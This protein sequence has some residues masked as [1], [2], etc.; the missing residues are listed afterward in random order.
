MGKS[1]REKRSRG[2]TLRKE[3]DPSVQ[4]DSKFSFKKFYLPVVV[5][6]S[7][8][9]FSLHLYGADYSRRA[10]ALTF[11]E[12]LYARLG[13]Q[14]KNNMGYGTDRIYNEQLK[15]G[16]QLP[17]YVNKPIFRHPPGFCI[18][19]Q[20]ILLYFSGEKGQL[21]DGR[22]VSV[23]QQGIEYHGMPVDCLGILSGQEIF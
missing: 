19:Y 6:I 10:G 14:I 20:C 23:R 16:R 1:K 12:S 8:I 3:P 5:I 17:D 21:S 9:A 11:D 2:P 22:T 18:A 7:I 13:Y 4:M 15:Q